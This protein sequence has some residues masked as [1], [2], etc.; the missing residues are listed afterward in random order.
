MEII[1][2][3][4]ELINLKDISPFSNIFITLLT[5]VGFLLCFVLGFRRVGNILVLMVSTSS[6]IR[7]ALQC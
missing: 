1:T 2:L 4:E 3:R 7:S 5:R 6:S